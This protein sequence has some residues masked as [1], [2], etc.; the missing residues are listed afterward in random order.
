MQYKK[1]LCR[2]FQRGSCQYG[3]RCKFLHV[4]QQQPKSNASGFG[5]QAGTNQH[6]K[7]NPFGFGVPI[8]SQ[9]KGANDFGSKQNQNKPFENKWTRFSPIPTSDAPSSRK[10]EN[11][12]QP[13]NH[14]CT[15]PDSC[16]R[17]I[18]ED[19]ENERPLWK[20]TCYSHWKNATCDIVGDVSYEEL[21]A[22]AYDDAKRGLSLQSI[23]ERERNLLN[24]K[25][26]EFDNLLRN[27]YTG[28]HKSGVAS[29]SPFPAATAIAFS[30]SPQNSAPPAVSSFSQL[31]SSINT[32]FGIR[33]S[34]PS[35]NAFGQPNFI[36]NSS[37]TS[38]AFATNNVPSANSGSFGNQFPAQATRSSF[39]SNATSSS[40]SGVF[41]AGSNQ[42][43]TPATTTHNAS[44]FS[45]NNQSSV[46][47]SRPVTST[48]A[49][50]QSPINIQLVK[51]LESGTVTGDASVW[52][53]EKWIPGEIPEEAP[54][55][56][57]VM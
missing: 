3:E 41:G 30:P 26:V 13:T 33:P 24:S 53:K 20:L 36:P 49:A 48:N 6:Q 40:N 1:D 52:L 50:E 10:P 35:N 54:P 9:S 29:Q 15:D 23:V 21:R 56:A 42:F 37:Q 45:F 18:A 46:L 17:L 22:A 57:F 2:N 55:D 34:A 27:P 51:N 16:K 12:P 8:N 38:S 14:K 32:G 47:P 31:G 28:P 39:T 7:P 4:T 44:P 25:L 19:F 11:H 5:A 43:S